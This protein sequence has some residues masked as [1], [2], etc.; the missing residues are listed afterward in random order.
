MFNRHGNHF[1]YHS[2]RRSDRLFGQHG[3]TSSG[4][5]GLLFGRRGSGSHGGL[6]LGTALLDDA[7]LDDR[8]LGALGDRFL[9]G[10]GLFILLIITATTYR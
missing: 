2:R 7:R 3:R 4:R 1:G 6:L 10:S 8:L 9:L 5:L